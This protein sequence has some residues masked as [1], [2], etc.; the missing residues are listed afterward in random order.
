MSVQAWMSYI[1]SVALLGG[2]ACPGQSVHMSVYIYM[3]MDVRH[4]FIVLIRRSVI[5]KTADPHGCLKVDAH[6]I[7]HLNVFVRR[8]VMPRTVGPHEC[9]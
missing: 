6:V 7:H 1:T 9:M 4:C 2:Q 8:L 5:S 3:K